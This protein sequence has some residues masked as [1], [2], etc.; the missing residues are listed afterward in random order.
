MEITFSDKP[1]LSHKAEAT[2][3]FLEQDFSPKPQL[4]ELAAHYFPTLL[5]F[6][7]ESSFTAKNGSLLIVPCSVQK[8][9][10]YSHF[11]WFG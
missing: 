6:M 7:H 3:L 4:Q 1:L 5:D 8:K 9:E 2:V 10:S 11:C